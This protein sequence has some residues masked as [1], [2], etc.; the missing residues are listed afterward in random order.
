MGKRAAHCF[1]R[2]RAFIRKDM[3]GDKVQDD[4]TNKRAEDKPTNRDVSLMSGCYCRRYQ[5]KYHQD[6]NDTL[7]GLRYIGNPQEP[8]S[9]LNK[10]G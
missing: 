1:S 3:P 4:T 7:I 9:I 2:C 10:L 8:G 6:N 5:G